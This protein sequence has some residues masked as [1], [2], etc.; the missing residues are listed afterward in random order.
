MRKGRWPFVVIGLCMM[1]ALG[2]G[3]ACAEGAAPATALSLPG[4]SQGL[5]AS[6]DGNTATTYSENSAW[7]D[8]EIHFLVALPFTA[9]YSYLATLSIDSVVKGTFPPEFRQT[10]AWLA[11]G[12]AVGASLAIALGSVGN[13]PDQSQVRPTPPQAGSDSGLRR[14]HDAA[15]E[16]LELVRITY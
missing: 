9:F 10:D 4:L 13:V 1:V 3:A 11:I 15:V 14:N 8:F 16:K 2:Q 12:F 5:G 6:P 7:H